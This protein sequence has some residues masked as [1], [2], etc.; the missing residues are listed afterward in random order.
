M[1]FIQDGGGNFAFCLCHINIQARPHC[2][3]GPMPVLKGAIVTFLRYVRLVLFLV[4]ALVFGMAAKADVSGRP[5]A[6]VLEIELFQPKLD[7]VCGLGQALGKGC[8]AIRARPVVPSQAWPWRTIGRVNAAGQNTRSHCT[9]TLL[10]ARIV[11]TA[12]HCLY[13]FHR[14]SWFPANSLTFVAAYAQGK[15]QGVAPILRYVVDPAHDPQSRDFKAGFGRDWA[16]LVL[17]DPIERPEGYLP[18][19]KAADIAA[20]AAY[21]LAGYPALRPHVLSLAEDCGPAA[22]GIGTLVYL[23][24]CAAMRGDSGAPMLVKTAAGYQIIG[25]FVGTYV[26]ANEIY[27]VAVQNQ[28]FAQALT[29]LLAQ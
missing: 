16:L 19:V 8:D 5:D 24:H 6:G 20:D 27:S 21:L 4:G 3:C 29:R 25:V 1:Y 13:N 11:L 22:K 18:L 2:G 12:S 7:A 15:A 23:H 14:K 10:S 17:R 9:G 26:R 28:V